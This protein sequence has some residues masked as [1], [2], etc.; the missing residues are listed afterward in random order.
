MKKIIVKKLPF[1][2][3]FCL[4]HQFV[5][6]QPTQ[7]NCDPYHP[8]ELIIEIDQ[9]PP[10]PNEVTGKAA[11]EALG[12][13]AID[14]IIDGTY[15]KTYLVDFQLP[16][17]YFNTLEEVHDFYECGEG[18]LP[19]TTGLVKYK[20]RGSD[21]NYFISVNNSS[22]GGVNY[23]LDNYM[24]YS[25][26]QEPYPGITPISNPCN[27]LKVAI[28]DTGSQPTTPF[29]NR[30]L[31]NEGYDFIDNDPIAYGLHQHGTNIESIIAAETQ[32]NAAEIKFIPVRV[33][34]D[35]A[36]G[37]L[38][39]TFKG[40]NYAIDHA[41]IIVMCLESLVCTD[42]LCTTVYESILA[43]ADHEN[44]LIVAAA[45]NSSR[46]I[47]GPA[48]YSIPGSGTSQN[49]LVVGGSSCFEE[50]AQFSNYGAMNVDLFA[51]SEDILVYPSSLVSGTSFAAPQIASVVAM[52]ALTSS[53]FEAEVLK[54]FVMG[55]IIDRGWFEECV[56]G[57]TFDYS[58]DFGSCPPSGGGKRNQ[59]NEREEH[60]IKRNISMN[61]RFSNNDLT[62]S[63]N[64]QEY[65]EVQLQIIHLS[66]TIVTSQVLYLNEGN[67]EY[68]INGDKL[69][70]GIYMVALKTNNGEITY[71]KAM[72]YL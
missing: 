56:S 65:Q 14:S 26:C 60:S 24:P 44:K 35:L 15:Y 54:A 5:F 34:D 28:L 71:S 20:A 22:T 21:Y 43:K 45:G 41:E 13:D 37:E 33:L 40:L 67:N 68:Q 36:E 1:L 12:G 16:N 39:E 25:N 46:S 72:K 23:D 50:T 2:L 38:W 47:D 55:N 52:K 53:N 31:M 48:Y 57:G 59:A 49:L 11:F 58:K 29:H 18:I 51:P 66:G 42:D 27:T 64:S 70:E 61:S 62:V 4:T 17:A 69:P 32:N 9:T 19:T 6:S 63:I 3:L 10:G 30:V 7:A 8:S